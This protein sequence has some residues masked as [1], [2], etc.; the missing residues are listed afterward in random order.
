MFTN[1][2]FTIESVD[3][4]E[5]STDRFIDQY[6]TP[7]IP[8]VVR[9]VG[10]QWPART[11]WTAEA[12]RAAL[13]ESSSVVR[14]SYWHDSRPDF[15]A[16]D[17]PTPEFVERVLAPS[18]SYVR[19]H[20]CR[21]WIQKTGVITPWHV[22]AQSIYII[23]VQIRGRKEWSIVSPQTPLVTY[24][25][26][27]FAVPF[28]VIPPPRETSYSIPPSRS[29]KATCCFC[30]RTG[31]IVLRPSRTRSPSTGS[32][33]RGVVVSCPRTRFGRQRFSSCRDSAV[34]S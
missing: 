7:E 9:G 11:K 34:V 24:P 17:L 5:M 27:T 20:H 8:V 21:F 30:H 31:S 10:T 18:C 26:D 29:R 6:F 33:R 16:D 3:A 32:A 4:Y 23:C 22:D 25:F 2:P 13:T 15:V 19:P 28:D 1:G 14:R 12:L